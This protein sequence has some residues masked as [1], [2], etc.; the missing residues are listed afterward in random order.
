MA[1]KYYAVKKGRKKG[2]FTS[3]AD[4]QKVISGYSNAEFKSFATLEEAK[5]YLDN[6]PQTIDTRDPELLCAYVDGS[7][8]KATKR[9]SYGVVLIKNNKILTTIANSDNHSDYADSFQIAGECF[10]AL[11]AIKWAINHDYDRIVI[12]YD[13]LGIEMWAKGNWRANKPVSKDYVA[14]FKKFSAKIKVDF[15]KVKAHSGIEYNELA[16]Q[17]AKD[18]LK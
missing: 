1:K 11:N 12:F 3:W 13:Y 8:D 17:L 9:Y 18:A 4:T 6:T 7:F 5:N 16:D 14:H 2:V 10:G 15:V